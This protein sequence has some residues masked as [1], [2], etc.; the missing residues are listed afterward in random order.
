MT[1][2]CCSRPI[3]FQD[4]TFLDEI[5]HK[6]K[7]PSLASYADR[8]RMWHDSVSLGGPKQSPLLDRRQ[9]KVREKL[10]LL[11]NELEVMRAPASRDEQL[12]VELWL[13]DINQRSLRPV[14]SS[15]I[16]FVDHSRAQHFALE[17]DSSMAAV[18]GFT[19]GAVRTHKRPSG[20][21]GAWRS[22]TSF[23]VRLESPPYWNLPI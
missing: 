7:D 16:R 10:I 23:P 19:H 13:R 5:A 17:R 18:R 22:F 8:R 6:A 3:F 14:A 12:K 4:Y 11:R 21:P 20:E 9:N 2:Y 1:C 15:E